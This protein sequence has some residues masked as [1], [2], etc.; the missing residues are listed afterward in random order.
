MPSLLGDVR[1]FNRTVTEHIGVLSDHFLGRGLNPNEA[2]LLWEIGPSG[3]ELRSLRARLALDSGY[4]TRLVRSLTDARPGDRRAEPGRPSQQAGAADEEGTGR[5]GP[6]RPALRRVRAGPARSA[7][8]GA[9]ARA[10]RGHAHRAATAGRR[11]RRDPG[12]RS[13]APG[14]ADAAWRRTTPSSTPGRGRTSTRPRGRRPSP[15][16][17]VRRA[18]CSWWPTS[19]G[20][21]WAAARSSTTRVGVSDVK[22]MWVHDGARGRGVGRRLLE[23]LEQRAVE[24]GDSVVRLETSAAS[25]RGDLAL[26]VRRL[27]RGRAVQRRTLCGPLVLED[28]VSLPV[29]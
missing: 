22:R 15:T 17:C 1:R 10:G 6:A 29:E 16:R 25:Q 21:R 24:H 8:R 7:D 14:R 4:L 11:D 18:A 2:R 9:A 23:D 13:R 19:G 5:A 26:P 3:S 20:A 12:G 28:A 27:R